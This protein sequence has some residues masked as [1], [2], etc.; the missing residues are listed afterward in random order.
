MTFVGDGVFSAVIFRSIDSE[1]CV[2]F[3]QRLNAV[4]NELRDVNYDRKS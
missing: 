3:D 2:P 1:L 4:L